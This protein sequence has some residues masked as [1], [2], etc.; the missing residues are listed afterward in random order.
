M[1]KGNEDGLWT[2]KCWRQVLCV[3]YYCSSQRRPVVVETKGSSRRAELKSWLSLSIVC[4]CSA[5]PLPRVWGRPSAWQWSWE[6]WCSCLSVQSCPSG[7]AWL[8]C[9]HRV[10]V[11]V[12]CVQHTSRPHRPPNPGWVLL[13]DSVV[14]TFPIC[15]DFLDQV[16]IRRQEV[17]YPTMK[18]RVCV[19]LLVKVIPCNPWFWIPP[20]CAFHHFY[21]ERDVICVASAGLCW[22]VSWFK[23]LHFRLLIKISRA[24]FLHSTW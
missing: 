19:V 20:L 18:P 16:A 11:Q 6:N 10:C 22:E 4:K 8:V 15:S 1:R 14:L 12:T 23:A 5:S 9:L 21:E 13:V 7:E 24:L 2:V 17:W 3:P